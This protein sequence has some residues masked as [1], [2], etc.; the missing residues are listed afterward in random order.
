M[1]IKSGINWFALVSGVLMIVVVGLSFFT[2]WWQLKIGSNLATI[3]ADPFYTNFGVLGLEFVVPILFAF[4][5]G[6]MVLFVISGALLIL[7]SIQPLK[8][9]GKEP[10]CY[11][12][13]RPIYT[14]I[15]FVI[16][17]ALIAYAVPAAINT[18]SGGQASL[19]S[20]IFP[21]VGAST[22]QLPTGMSSGSGSS[23]QV[24]VSIITSFQYPFY[25]AVVATALAIVARFYHGK[26]VIN[27]V[28]KLPETPP[29]LASSKM[30]STPT[31]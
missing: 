6:A 19:A 25:L 12:Y 5:I 29:I 14:I 18:I 17:L 31:V 23:A 16:V 24:G 20:P 7:Y 3:N 4:N 13:K 27:Q 26:I 1:S 10:L 15:S 30:P 11:G 2:P 9:Y 8:S 22:V 21:I 28:A